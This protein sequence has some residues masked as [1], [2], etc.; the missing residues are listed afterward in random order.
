[1]ITEFD[2]KGKIFTN[3]IA[4]KPVPAV[5]QTLTHRIHGEVHVR[6]SERLKD[7]MNRSEK[8]LAITDAIVY[9]TRGQEIYRC[10]FLTLNRDQIVWLIPDEEISTDHPGPGGKT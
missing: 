1:M 4:K 10:G 2:D 9:D 6:P 3:V 7:E 5:V 8:F